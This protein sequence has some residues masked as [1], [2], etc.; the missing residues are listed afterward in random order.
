MAV[1]VVAA[2]GCEPT[3][4]IGGGQGPAGEPG[5]DGAD[6]A[7]G[8][9]GASGCGVSDSEISATQGHAG[10]DSP[11]AGYYQAAPGAPCVLS[12]GASC[13]E[14][15]TALAG[16]CYAYSSA[17]GFELGLLRLTGNAFLLPDDPQ[18]GNAPTGW[19]CEAMADAD[20]SGACPEDGTLAV[21][22]LCRPTCD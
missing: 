4:D 6:G 15:Q 1:L 20:E 11:G 2:L 18:L 10:Y 3:R 22:V 7:P 9:D 13:P 21:T 19:W 12:I 8:D 14:G 17:S 16:A 5:D